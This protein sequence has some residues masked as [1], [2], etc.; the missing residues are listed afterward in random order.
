MKQRIFGG[1][2]VLAAACTPTKDSAGARAGSAESAKR[3]PPGAGSARA[4]GQDIDPM[5]RENLEVMAREVLSLRPRVAELERTN[6]Q[7]QARIAGNPSTEVAAAGS[8]TAAPPADLAGLSPDELQTLADEVFA[9]R[10]RVVE[11]ETENRTLSTK[12]TAAAPVEPTVPAVPKS[13]F[14]FGIADATGSREVVV[15]RDIVKI[16]KDSTMC[17]VVLDGARMMHAVIERTPEGVSIID[18]GTKEGTL[19]NGKPI[20]KA[21]LS[22]G[23]RIGIADARLVVVFGPT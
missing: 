23:D 22:S 3:T 15:A 4:S 13:G 17:Q 7:L 10:R 20:T 18:M 21:T 9:L 1:C 16:G 2:L 11:L 6:R 5:Q 12:V 14:A 8:G 19:V